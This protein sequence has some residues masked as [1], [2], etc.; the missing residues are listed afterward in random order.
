LELFVS[1]RLYLDHAATTPM[2]AQA[3]EAVLSGI[4]IW[5][6]PSSPHGEGRAARKALEEARGRVAAAYGW[7]SEVLF[8]GG[9]SEALGIAL[10][11]AQ[12][13]ERWASAVEHDAVW[14]SGANPR[15]LAVDAEGVVTDEALAQVTGGLACVQ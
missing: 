3:R 14:R 6:N 5:A 7:T 1:D 9:A 10:G 11:R 4:A 8:T 2:T 13:E 12:V 15:V